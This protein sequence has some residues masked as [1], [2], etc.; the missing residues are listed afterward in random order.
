[1]LNDRKQR[2]NNM[3]T[4]LN[5]FTISFWIFWRDDTNCTPFTRRRIKCVVIRDRCVHLSSFHL[6]RTGKKHWSMI[7]NLSIRV[8]SFRFPFD[9]WLRNNSFR[10]NHRIHMPYLPPWWT[11][12]KTRAKLNR[13]QIINVCASIFGTCPVQHPCRTS[14]IRYATRLIRNV[15]SIRFD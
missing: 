2:C 11:T 12:T 6:S 10:W 14:R 7:S 9:L 4:N 13:P 15:L 8:P 5:W 3:N 1:M